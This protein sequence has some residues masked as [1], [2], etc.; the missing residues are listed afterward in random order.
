MNLKS[1]ISKHQARRITHPIDAGWMFTDETSCVLA[2]AYLAHVAQSDRDYPVGGE[3]LAK[4]G[5]V[6][7]EDQEEL[8]RWEIVDESGDC[9][10]AVQECSRDGLLWSAEILGTTWPVDIHYRGQIY[11][12]C[13]ALEVT[14]IAK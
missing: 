13:L 9:V 12:L 4:C 2:D 14:P 10:I 5:F 11:D 3:W 7:Y 1:A 6:Y 8:A